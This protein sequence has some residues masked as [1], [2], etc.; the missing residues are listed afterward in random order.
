MELPPPEVSPNTIFACFEKESGKLEL[1][2][3]AFDINIYQTF[4]LSLTLLQI[5]IACLPKWEGWS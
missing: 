5:F 3:Q 2:R 1:F 4:R